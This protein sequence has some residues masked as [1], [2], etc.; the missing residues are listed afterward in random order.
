MNQMG[1]YLIFQVGEELYCL[2]LLEV[3]EIIR[4]TDI[5]PLHEDAKFIKGVINLRGSIIPIMD[6]RIKFGLEEYV[7][8]ERNVIIIVQIK[9]GNKLIGLTVD[10]VFDVAKFNDSDVKQSSEIGIDI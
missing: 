9:E 8:H 2:S 6:M 4:Y 10:R 7:N 5:C 3:M 1:R